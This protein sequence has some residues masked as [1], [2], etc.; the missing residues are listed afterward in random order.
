MQ[1]AKSA[2]RKAL[3]VLGMHRSGTSV[4]SA[5]LVR[6]GF[7]APRDLMPATLD[8]PQGYWESRRIA[9]INNR[10]LA[11][12][13]THWNDDSQI[14][15]QWLTSQERDSDVRA[16]QDVVDKE[17]GP[18]ERLLIK[19]PRLCRLLP[20]WVKALSADDIAIQCIL[21][22]R[23]PNAVASSLA[24]RASNKEFA[25]A[26][27]CSYS[28]AILLWL[29]Y[30][31]DAEMR[32]RDSE[33]TI[34]VYDHLLSDWKSCLEPLFEGHWLESFNEDTESEMSNIIQPGYR[35]HAYNSSQGIHPKEVDQLLDD[36]MQ[37]LAKP[38]HD[39]YHRLDFLRS[40]LD[41]FTEHY[42]DLRV[43]YDN[44]CSDDCWSDQILKEL[45]R[46]SI[47]YHSPKATK[48][49]AV[50]ISASP[51][52]KGHIYRV[53][54]IAL[55]LR[56]SGWATII[57]RID[58]EDIETSLAKASIAVVFRATANDQFNAIRSSCDTL[59]IPLIYDI[60][61]LLFDPEVTSSG[62]IAYLDNLPEAER[63]K[64]ILDSLKYKDALKRCDASIL[65]TEPLRQRASLV[66]KICYMI[67]NISSP[68]VEQIS[69]T[70]LLSPRLSDSDGI[71]RLVFASG[72]E[73]HH[74][75]FKIVAEG[76]ALTFQQ[77]PSCSL[78]V[79]GHLDISLY[80]SLA[81]FANRIIRVPVIPFYDLPIELSKYDI[82]LCPLEPA[83]DFCAC[84]SAVR[85][86]VPSLVNTPSIASTTPSLRDIIIHG[87]TGLLV[88]EDSPEAW[89][90]AIS[91][92]LAD[93]QKRLAMAKAC[94][95]DVRARYGH[96]S[97]IERISMVF[98]NLSCL[99]RR[100]SNAYQ[101]SPTASI[102]Y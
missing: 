56:Y 79:I 55:A 54:N 76:I 3:I 86:L 75:D 57:H 78:V 45:A 28:R 16:I 12:A 85:C 82:N 36:V 15:E 17:F 70:T 95:I 50:F 42:K 102:L 49:T 63:Q 9:K 7:D 19:D 21:I 30:T 51:R 99:S 92:L 47:Y 10:L 71:Q 13:H 5:L 22:L 94:C 37:W 14:S 2:P 60:D 101:S 100:S 39:N 97:W 11:A 40:R 27:I 53:E 61:D 81:P 74:R 20:L 65:T 91:S 90:S 48:H 77:N 35:H 88:E 93:R 98:Q 96:S 67:P 18:S 62:Q 69:S 6:A 25:P 89:A 4:L 68:R 23:H 59:E 83:N 80:P 64:W 73:S 32:S 72:T 1:A 44:L 43:N 24:A 52:S 26:A 31:L 66:S 38:G 87:K 34:I 46:D 8:N 84:K 41:Y 33:R 58:D 29:R